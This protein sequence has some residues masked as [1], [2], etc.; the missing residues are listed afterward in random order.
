VASVLR[1]AAAK[2]IVPLLSTRAERIFI[3]LA[4][5]LNLRNA[6]VLFIMAKRHLVRKFQFMNAIRDVPMLSGSTVTTAWRVLGLWIEEMAS[7]Y[8]G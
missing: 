1:S 7:R 3:C 6:R 8:G 5:T 4:T 2:K